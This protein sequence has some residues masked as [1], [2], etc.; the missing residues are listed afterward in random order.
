MPRTRSRRSQADEA[1]AGVRLAGQVRR[2]PIEAIDVGRARIRRDLGRVGD[3]AASL[4]E[5]GLLNPITVYEENGRFRLIAGERRLRAAQ[6]L[7]STHIDAVVRSVAPDEDA[8]VLELVEN[9]QRRELS[10]EE[11]ADAFITLVRDKGHQMIG[12]AQSVG[13]S[14]AYISKRIRVFEDEALRQSIAR[15]HI[16]VSLAEELLTLPDEHRALLLAQA[17]QVDWSAHGGRAA[18]RALQQALM[19]DA[20]LTPDGES[21]LG[22]DAQA[23]EPEDFDEP[24]DEAMLAKSRREAAGQCLAM[25][26]PEDLHV[27]IRELNRVLSALRPFQFTRRDDREMAA[28]FHTLRLIA[29][30]TREQRTVFPSLEEAR[31]LGGPKA[32]RR[33]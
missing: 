23:D 12:V 20:A 24:L 14:V 19:A 27:H 7:G 6:Q 1:A 21:E 2:I 10:D 9:L 15:G 32:R 29:Q 17:A 16:S 31:A 22:V 33:P 18:I 26:R 13:R 28:L 4:N 8:V 3:L 11:E 30:A 25:E 5:T